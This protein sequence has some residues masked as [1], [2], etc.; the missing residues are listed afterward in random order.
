MPTID[1]EYLRPISA[2]RYPNKE[3][4]ALVVC[5]LKEIVVVVM[6]PVPVTSVH[7]EGAQSSSYCAA[8]GEKA[9]QAARLAV[10]LEGDGYPC[11]RSIKTN[12]LLST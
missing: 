11:F 5:R 7:T 3:F 6:P 8:A 9:E 12:S 1:L 2:S 10:A 4:K